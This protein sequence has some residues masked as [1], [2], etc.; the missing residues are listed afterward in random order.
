MI[1]VKGVSRYFGHNVA[2]KDLDLT[3]HEGEVLGFLGPN[4]AG[5]TTTMRMITGF[6]P[7]SEGSIT[8]AGYDVAEDPMEVKKLIGYLPE[9]NPLYREMIVSDY[10]DSMAG[11]KGIG[12]ARLRREE[13]DRVLEMVELVP[14]ARRLVGNLSRGYRQRV[15]LARALLGDPKIL[16]MDEPTASLDPKQI[17]EIRELIKSLAGERTVIISSHILPEIQMMC[18]RVAI[19]NKGRLVAEDTPDRLAETIRGQRRLRVTVEG[20][21]KEVEQLLTSIA[22]VLA[23][24]PHKDGAGDSLTDNCMTWIVEQEP[25]SDVRKELFFSLSARGWPLLELAPMDISL[26]EIFLQLTT[27]ETEMET[28]GGKEGDS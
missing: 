5:K 28:V 25:A 20:P 9:G 2:V 22:G 23:C 17:I 14:V 15:G 6:I 27:E 16:I 10:L 4:G 26:E 3:V 7:P 13:V 21:Q 11:I 12:P 1:Q 18:E 19:I 24:T 8:V